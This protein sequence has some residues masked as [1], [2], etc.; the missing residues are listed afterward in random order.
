MLN[1][2]T[3][4]Q[5]ERKQIATALSRIPK[6]PIFSPDFEV[7]RGHSTLEEQ[8]SFL[9]L[10]Q[11]AHVSSENASANW[12]RIR[13]EFAV[14]ALFSTV[15]YSFSL[16]PKSMVET[17]VFKVREPK[18]LLQVSI[19]DNASA[20]T[21][22]ADMLST[23]T[24]ASRIQLERFGKSS[25]VLARCPATAAGPPPDQSAYESLFQSASSIEANYRKLLGALQMVP[26]ELTRLNAVST[27]RAQTAVKKSVSRKAPDKR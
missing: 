7:D 15:Q 27:V 20:V 4:S 9:S 2:C 12:V 5:E 16:D 1:V 19:E 10:S 14:Q 17:L 22:P 3:P 8:P 11:K 18:D 6:Q 13:R 26:D 23:N 24:P 21:S 25:V